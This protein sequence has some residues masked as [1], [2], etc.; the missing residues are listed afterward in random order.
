[1]TVQAVGKIRKGRSSRRLKS[2]TRS[3]TMLPALRYNLPLTEPLNQDQINR[4]DN[5]SM[6]IL[7]NTGIHFRDKIALEDWR[8]IG[9][10]I[11][12]ETAFLDRF[13]VKDLIRS[14]PETFTYHARNTKNKN[15]KTNK[16]FFHLNFESY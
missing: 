5:A 2:Q 9:A 3:F 16:D 12:G 14:I 15:C 8:S 7:E 6:D 10:K 1:M 4:I 13:L 11:V